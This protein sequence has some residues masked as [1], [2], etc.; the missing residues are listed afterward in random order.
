M[1]E[2]EEGG[3]VKVRVEGLDDALHFLQEAAQKLPD[4]ADKIIEDEAEFIFAQSQRE[5]P[6]DTGMLQRSGS[7]EHVRLKSTVG[8]NTPYAQFVHDGTSMVEGRPYLAGPAESRVPEIKRK[9][10]EILKK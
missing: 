7:H 4:E 10:E 6:V 9:L 3:L 1:G 2:G 5:V 8:Y